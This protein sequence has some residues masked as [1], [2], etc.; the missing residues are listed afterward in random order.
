VSLD[1]GPNTAIYACNL[2]YNH[3]NKKMLSSGGICFE[4][5][6]KA[7]QHQFCRLVFLDFLNALL[8]K[9]FIVTP[10]IHFWYELITVADTKNE[11]LFFISADLINRYKKYYFSYRLT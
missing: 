3:K 2:F 9:R 10:A 6:N 4:G 8:E 1:F 7:K 5:Q 11:L